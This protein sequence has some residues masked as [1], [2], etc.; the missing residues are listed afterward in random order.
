MAMHPTPARQSATPR[1][2]DP[3]DISPSAD[4]A[5]GDGSDNLYLQAFDSLPMAMA[6]LDN[7]ANIVSVN[8]EWR[9][10]GADNGGAE[11]SYLGYNYLNVCGAAAQPDAPDAE[12][13]PD[14]ADADG[15]I[16]A[17]LSGDR[18]HGQLEY[19]CHAPTRRRWFLMQTWRF[20]D[21]GQLWLAVMHVDIT[22]RRLIE[23]ALRERAERD[24]LTGLLSR[25]SFEERSEQALARA[26]R[27]GEPVSLLFLDLNEFKSINDTCGHEIGDKVLKEVAGR[28]QQ[29]VRE[30]DTPARLGGDEFAVI[31]DGTDAEIAATIVQRIKMLTSEPMQIEDHTFHLGCAI[32]IATASEGDTTVQQLLQEADHAMYAEKK[33]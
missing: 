23:D 9:R 29:G 31:L 16:R 2:I 28:L 24:T 6:I 15:L 10:F 8:A 30:M 17:I 7:K 18:E 26:R 27:K 32:G 12:A 22:R 3:T 21:S 19:P 20:Y 25:A 1:V 33:R 14:A 13:D 5:S 11:N 4:E